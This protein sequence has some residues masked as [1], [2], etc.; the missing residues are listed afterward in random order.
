MLASPPAEDSGLGQNPFVKNDFGGGNLR[1]SQSRQLSPK[2]PPQQ[3]VHFHLFGR[4]PP[5]R[6]QRLRRD[7]IEFMLRADGMLLGMHLSLVADGAFKAAKLYYWLQRLVVNV[8]LYIIAVLIVT[9]TLGTAPPLPPQ[10]ARWARAR[11]Q[12]FPYCP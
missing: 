10:S 12:T 7:L 6:R 3:R 1:T 9:A 2:S 8:A 5:P 11:R 4:L